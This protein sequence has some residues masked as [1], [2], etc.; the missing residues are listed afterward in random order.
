MSLESDELDD[1]FDELF[2]EDSFEAE[3][4]PESFEEESFEL[5]ESW[6]S[7]FPAAALSLVD[8]FFPA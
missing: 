6:E 4:L 3:S 7:D 1:S 8:D 2:E 5:D